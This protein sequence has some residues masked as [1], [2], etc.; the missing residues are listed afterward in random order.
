M[1]MRT[2]KG[3]FEEEYKLNKTIPACG[4]SFILLLR[5]TQESGRYISL[6][7]SFNNHNSV[8]YNC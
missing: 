3:G 7:I 1:T 6:I 4:V 8:H 5:L 2:K